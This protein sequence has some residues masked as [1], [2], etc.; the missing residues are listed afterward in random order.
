MRLKFK[1]IPPE[2]EEI[3]DGQW[4]IPDTNISIQDCK[5]YC[6]FYVVNADVGDGVKELGGYR[7]LRDAKLAAIKAIKAIKEN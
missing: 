1:Y 5:H 7:H 2:F 3:E 4:I 6:G